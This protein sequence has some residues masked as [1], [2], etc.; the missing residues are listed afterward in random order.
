MRGFAPLAKEGGTRS[1][2]GT[3]GA[4]PGGKQPTPYEAKKARWPN[5]PPNEWGKPTDTWADMDIHTRR[6]LGYKE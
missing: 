5:S 3:G 2:D 4:G 1:G 6:A